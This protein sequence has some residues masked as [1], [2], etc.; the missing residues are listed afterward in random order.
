M[1][2]PAKYWIPSA[3][4]SALFV[5]E[6]ML[7]LVFGL[8][9]PMLF[10]ADADTGYRYRPNQ[11]IFRF[12]NKIEYN[13]YSQRSEP[14]T[15]RKPQGTVRILLVGDSII[16][17]GNLTDQTQTISALFEARLAA[18]RKPVQ[19]LNASAGSWAISN[20]LGYLRKF[21]TFESDAVIVQIGT[22]DLT[23]PPST[24]ARIGHDPFYPDQAPL[25]AIQEAWTRYAWPKFG[26]VLGFGTGSAQVSMPSPQELD[27]QLQQNLHFLEALVILV[28]SQQRPIYVLFT[29][30]LNNLVPTFNVPQYK[31]E[32]LKRLDSL[33]VSVIDA[34][35][36]WSTLPK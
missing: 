25:L 12:G 35:K 36:A 22:D 6:L 20:R 17:G 19:V 13:Q 14:V 31:P 24:S 4:I 21:G 33:H 27:Q 1:K 2:F 23:Q 32:F 3:V 29:P 34:H 8:G 5:T 18:S 30:N 11:T 16:N 7:R 26:N 10:Q 9:N 15:I 28:R